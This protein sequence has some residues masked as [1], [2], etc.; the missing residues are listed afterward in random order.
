M[1]VVAGI[2]KGKKID[3]LK[4]NTIRPTA[5]RVKESVFNIL[6]AQ[7]I[8]SQVLDLYSGS[9]ALGIEA[10]SRGAKSCIFVD[11][12]HEC[13]VVIKSNLERIGF[14]G[15]ILKRDAVQAINGLAKNG[16]KIDVL[17][18]DPPYDKDLAKNLLSQ[19]ANHDILTDSSII[20]IEHSQREEPVTVGRFVKIREKKY[21]D[22]IVSLYKVNK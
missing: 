11:N 5:D 19:L 20:I 12:N 8:D 3:T 22:T 14:N 4:G 1:R 6:G 13:A 15:E 18:A 7:I 10:L 17:F 21:G 16:V 2:A 9:G